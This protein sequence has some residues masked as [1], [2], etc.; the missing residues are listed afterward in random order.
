M[1]YLE[2][3]QAVQ[4]YTANTEPS[5]V[6]SIDAFINAAETRIAQEAE[7]PVQ[8]SATAL[9]LTPG[10]YVYDLSTVPGYIAIDSVALSTG[11]IEGADSTLTYLDNKD[12]EYLRTAFPDPTFLGT[13]RMYNVY[14]HRTLKL[15]PTPDTSMMLVL[16]YYSYPTS[17]IVSGTSW[18][19]A[20]FPQAL[21]YGSL[22]DAAKYLKEEADVV[23]MYEA[24]YQEA[25]AEIKAF[26]DKRAVLDQY[27]KRGN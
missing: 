5:F 19:G 23:A 4:D 18:L 7:L 2:L 11:G 12:E 20:T 26:S 13:P 10:V 22:R 25:L 1:T 3:K 15:A 8:Q 9:G 17:I 24:G 21:L 16:R 6:A 14:D 27:R